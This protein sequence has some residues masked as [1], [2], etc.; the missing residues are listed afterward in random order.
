MEK[1]EIKVENDFKNI[2][3]NKEECIVSITS[4]DNNN[5]LLNIIEDLINEV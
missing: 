3:D 1:I 2:F 5:K 4:Q